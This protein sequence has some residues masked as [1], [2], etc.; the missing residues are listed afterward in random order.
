M[1][2]AGGDH[3]MGSRRR[4]LSEAVLRF[5]DTVVAGRCGP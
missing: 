4:P 5:L 3:F 1:T 2:I